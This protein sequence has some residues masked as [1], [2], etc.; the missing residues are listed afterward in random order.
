MIKAKLIFLFLLL[1]VAVYSQNSKISIY[2]NIGK[3][4]L[5]QQ[6]KDLINI[7]LDSIDIQST[8]TVKIISSTDYLGSTK[9][10]F[11][12]AQNRA[13]EI[14]Q[15]LTNRYKDAFSSIKTVNNGEIEEKN[16][17][18]KN[19]KGNLKNRKTEIIFT[20]KIY[21][22]ILTPIIPKKK[23]VYIYNPVRKK[24]V[25][26]RGKKFILKN[27]IFYIG[28]DK[29]LKESYSSLRS[30]VRFLKEN[31]KVKI[32]INGHLC[33]NAGKY[34]PDKSKIIPL[35]GDDL[36]IKRA[37]LVYKYLVKNDIRKSRLS[38]Y[39]YG[40][41]SPIYYPEKNKSE[42]NKNKRV[43]IIITDF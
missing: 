42:M 9:S 35:K 21:K 40:F 13:N 29:I 6:N 43:E 4:K 32:D 2:Y 18:S 26:E 23:Q 12:L 20:K 33:C 11:K 27:L 3:Y 24:I 1:S 22:E 31:P 37:K 39:G 8:Y 36:S 34:Q 30:L 38:Y 7:F 17:S 28:T 14:K 41:Q 10:N 19:Q 25:L 16:K 5:N 15:L